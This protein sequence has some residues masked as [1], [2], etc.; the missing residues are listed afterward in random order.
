MNSS[1]VTYASNVPHLVHAI[2]D[3]PG[4]VLAVNLDFADHTVK[5]RNEANGPGNDPAYPK[6]ASRWL[7]CPRET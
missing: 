2:P 1:R 7:E 3:E 4:L 5:K 6:W